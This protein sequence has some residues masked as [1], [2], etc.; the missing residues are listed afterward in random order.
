MSYLF[1]N[2]T[3]QESWPRRFTEAQALLCVALCAAL[4]LLAP[5]RARAQADAGPMPASGGAPGAA[6][7][8][9]GA[10]PQSQPAQMQPRSTMRPRGVG[11]G[12][13]PATPVEWPVMTQDLNAKLAAALADWKDSSGAGRPPKIVVLDFCTWDNQWRPF[14][15]WVAD[16]LSAAWA[17]GSGGAFTVIDR[18]QLPAALQARGLTAKDEFESPQA[19]ALAQALGADIL[20]NGRYLALDNDLGLTVNVRPAVA[21]APPASGQPHPR[22]S[23]FVQ[24]RVTMSS[25]LA[26]HLGEPLAALGPPTRDPNA[27]RPNPNSFAKCSYCPAVPYSEQGRKKKI[28]GTV[29]LSV[30]ITAEGRASDI[31]VTKSLE[32]SLDQQAVKAVGTWI[33]DPAKDATGAP[34]AVHQNIEVSFHMY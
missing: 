8:T 11:F 1:R 19:T 32:P 5:G 3:K 16:N 14:G 29:L 7:A 17:A 15:A 21:A 25:D 33:F 27:P 10:T 24:S 20:V 30:L 13:A 26:G 28:E 22:P 23:L 31:T 4:L 6:P 34:V 9:D 2:V 18:A 12:A